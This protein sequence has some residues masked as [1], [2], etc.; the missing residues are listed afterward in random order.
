MG[1]QSHLTL[2]LFGQLTILQNEQLLEVK[3]HKAMAILVYLALQ[4]RP[5][6]R[7]F[8]ATLF[9]P[10]TRQERARANLRRALWTLNQTPV[11]A[12][13]KG[14]ANSV[15]L[16]HDDLTV[17]AMQF[18][19]LLAAGPQDFQVLEEAVSLYSGDLLIDFSLPDCGDFELWLVEQRES[20]HR[21]ALES[22]RTLTEQCLQQED[23]GAAGRLARRQIAMDNLQEPAYRQLFRALVG[24]GQRT[25][26]LSEYAT[27]RD[28]LREEL[29]AEPSQQTRVLIEQIRA[30][31]HKTAGQFQPA[32]ATGALTL[33]AS[34]SPDRQL[35]HV[36]APAQ[37][38][39]SPYR[40]LLSFRE[41]DASVF[42]G[43]EDFVSQLLL[44]TQQRPFTA[45]I[46]A[47]GAGKTSVIQAGLIPAL[48]RR[49]DWLVVST[50]PSSRPFHAL[51][52]SLLPGLDPGLS[53]T[54]LLVE[55]GRLAVALHAGQITLVDVLERLIHTRAA[56][57]PLR[58]LLFV[59]HFS[60]LF[61][62]AV[63]SA[64][65]QRYID[66]LLALG[67]NQPRP[68]SPQYAAL[69]AL[70]AD[71]LG[72]ALA[73]R[74][75]TNALH[76][77]DM[78]LGPMTR[79]ELTRAVVNPAH[80]Q[81][82]GFEY[83]LV[84]RILRDVG[85]E[86]GSLLLLEF[87]LAALWER[88]ESFLLTHAAY[89]AIGG[90]DAALAQHAES[91][92]AELTPEDQATARRVFM[93]LIRPGDG[94]GDTGRTATCDELGSKAWKLVIRLADSRLLV[95]GIDSSGQETAEITHAALIHHWRR[96][97]EWIEED[98]A[99]RLWQERLRTA[100]STWEI[101]F[102]DEGALLRGSTLATA[103]AWK[104]DRPEDLGQAESDYIAASVAFS[105]QRIAER[106]LER[107]ALRKAEYDLDASRR[108][109]RRLRVLVLL[110]TA[111]L[112][113]MVAA[114]I[115]LYVS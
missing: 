15:A 42:F 103:Q 2:R 61:T 77:A 11:G 67:D 72:Q 64:T 25:T 14:T 40:G 31:P 84:E 101:Q 63:D 49:G 102:R 78:M 114:G 106:G 75:L 4:H 89:E 18:E 27:L 66:A 104:I 21:R 50:R 55:T 105:M 32:A 54:D 85:S 56:G 79:A 12:W 113:T 99:F 93:Q 80:L 1:S 24:S 92:I 95:T 69:I 20:Y 7:D 108:R 29:S 70:R 39:P 5:Q 10:E 68:T 44:A 88:Q 48:R 51:A 23:Y 47:S 13:M 33:P 110:L 34:L 52:A 65:R 100:M 58:A 26:A 9:W 111:I 37:P 96:L 115:A 3:S 83:G 35:E 76:G 28:L 107:Q 97:S 38:P 71:F 57:R 94:T 43:R 62:D 19:T 16:R 87:A 59:D 46:G 112:L 8:L 90:V 41:E 45:V 98:R 73:Y 36:V 86:P 74:P 60:D 109:Q 53:S 6:S 91:V 17:D 82:V 30:D 81:Q 22:L